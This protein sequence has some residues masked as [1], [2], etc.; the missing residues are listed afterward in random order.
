M[1]GLGDLK[2]GASGAKGATE[3]DG[4]GHGGGG[5]SDGGGPH[6]DGGGPHGDG[7]SDGGDLVKEAGDTKLWLAALKETSSWVTAEVA[8][9][10]PIMSL[11][12][13][14]LVRSD[15]AHLCF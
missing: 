1:A 8:E 9:D 7:G 10:S 6:S 13:D 5:H 3:G 11:S 15:V 14:Q 2:K 4:G 12:D